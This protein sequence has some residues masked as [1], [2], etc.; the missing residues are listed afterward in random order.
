MDENS[1]LAHLFS[2]NVVPKPIEATTVRAN[3]DSLT[4]EISRLEKELQQQRAVI[5]AV[6]KLTLEILGAAR[7]QL[8]DLCLVSKSWCDAARQTPSLWKGI[9]VEYRDVS[10]DKIVAWYGRSGST[11]RTLEVI[12]PDIDDEC[13]ELD[14]CQS[15]NDGFRQ[16]L[17][18]GPTIDHLSIKC[19][20]GQCFTNFTFGWIWGDN[21][22]LS[23]PRPW[24]SIKSFTLT[25][26][27]RWEESAVNPD[28]PGDSGFMWIPPAVVSLQINLPDSSV[29]FPLDSGIA[30]PDMRIHLAE[31][32][33]L[34]TLTSFSIS[35]NWGGPHILEIVKHC[36]N[37]ETLAIDFKNSDLPDSRAAIMKQLSRIGLSLLKLR[38]LRLRQVSPST[39]G[40]LFRILKAPV[41]AQLDISFGEVKIWQGKKFDDELGRLVQQSSAAFR[42][43]NLRI[44]NVSLPPDDLNDILSALPSI[45][46]LTLDEVG[47]VNHGRKDIFSVLRE[48]ARYLPHIGV[49]EVLNASTKSAS[50]S[51]IP[52]LLDLRKKPLS[53]QP[54][55]SRLRSFTATF[56]DTKEAGS[57]CHNI[58]EM[59]IVQELRR[60]GL[61]VHV[62]PIGA[63]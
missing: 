53:G 21:V 14:D 10:Y 63:T 61:L 30:P 58:D 19:S 45:M 37:V 33:T 3:I 49:I 47:L 23:K 11:L 62:G 13:M 17:T 26:T 7:F 2:S 9:R 18:F 44:H 6:R 8:I 34:D 59:E 4:R 54:A 40:K 46:H 28:E 48:A 1:D 52:S 51:S 43:L 42:S 22:S 55:L 25:L 39:A 57:Q 15:P 16:L 41:L 56:E 24:D 31:A 29:A 35:C 27:G 32:W 20:S 50:P 36:K 5:S 12:P 38:T 60:S